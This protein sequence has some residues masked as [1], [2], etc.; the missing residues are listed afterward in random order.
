[1]PVRKWIEPRRGAFT[2]FTSGLTRYIAAT[3]SRCQ[4]LLYDDAIRT[5]DISDRINLTERVWQY[6]GDFV[7]TSI[8]YFNNSDGPIYIKA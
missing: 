7:V 2:T 5:L 6:G 1:M 8:T 3:S 4:I